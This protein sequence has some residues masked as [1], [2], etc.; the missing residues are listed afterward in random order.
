[1]KKKKDYG[2]SVAGRITSLNYELL[3]ELCYSRGETRSEYIG[4]VLNDYLD[5]VKSKRSKVA[6]MEKKEIE[7]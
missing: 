4:K 3:T 5:E 1:M 2:I 6:P 7:Q